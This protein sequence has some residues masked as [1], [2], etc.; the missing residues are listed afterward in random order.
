[1]SGTAIIRLVIDFFGI[2]MLPAA[3]VV[4]ELA[5]ERLRNAISHAAFA[6]NSVGV[7]TDKTLIGRRFQG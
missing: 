5:D 7:Q 6:W 3:S 4:K 2:T 1:L